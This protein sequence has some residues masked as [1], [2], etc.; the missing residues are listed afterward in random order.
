MDE[1]PPTHTMTATE[2]RQG[3]TVGMTRKI[4]LFSLLLVIPGLA[5][6][7]FLVLR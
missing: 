6:I 1:K 4:L 7:W 5:L 2:V 3:Q